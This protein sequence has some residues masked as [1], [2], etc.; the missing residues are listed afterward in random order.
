MT[1][2]RDVL[3]A[4][5]PKRSL[6]IRAPRRTFWSWRRS[7]SSTEV[8]LG[9]D[10]DHEQGPG[11]AMEGKKIDGA[12]LAVDRVGSLD[13]RFPSESFERHNGRAKEPRMAFVEQPIEC[14]APPSS[15]DISADLENA[16]DSAKRTQG[17]A[18][19]VATLNR[20][21]GRLGQLGRGGQ[22][23]LA[24]ATA[25]TECPDHQADASIVHRPDDRDR[26]LSE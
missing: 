22:V 8:R 19:E 9:L 14:S 15:A 24:P 10:L 11:C 21:D 17:E 6:A 25:T 16:E 5:Q 1:S 2:S 12:A 7:I 23:G 4:C 26:A 18:L 20:R 13:R 3:V